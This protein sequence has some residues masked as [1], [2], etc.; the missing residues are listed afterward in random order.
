MSM[1]GPSSTL[2]LQKFSSTVNS[3]GG[4]EDAWATV[5]SL[6]GV[7][8]KLEGKEALDALGLKVVSTH[9]FYLK[10]PFMKY[11]ITEQDRFILG[12]RIFNIREI[13]NPGEQNWF[14]EIKLQEIK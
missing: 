9:M 4:V 11:S 8:Q 14:L 12:S 2:Y 5:A 1:I 10:Y 7:I 6:T 3:E 13:I